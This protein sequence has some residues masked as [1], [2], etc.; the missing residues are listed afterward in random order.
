MIHFAD[1]IFI[2]IFSNEKVWISIQILLKFVNKDPFCNMPALDQIMSW[3]RIGEKQLSEPMM[4]W[5]TDA[6][7]RHS[8]SVS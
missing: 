5:S 8:A 2:C 7:M 4:V 6:Y 3:R 1:D